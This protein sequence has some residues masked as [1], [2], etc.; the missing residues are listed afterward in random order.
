MLTMRPFLFPI[1]TG[2]TALAHWK[3][4][5]TFTAITLSH[6]SSSISRNGLWWRSANKPALLTRISTVPNS[7]TVSDTRFSTDFFEVTSARTKIARFWV[8]AMRSATGLPSSTSETTTLAPAAARH[9][10]NFILEPRIHVFLPRLSLSVGS[11]PGRPQ[12]FGLVCRTG[13]NGSRHQIGKLLGRKKSGRGFPRPDF[14]RYQTDT[15]PA[16]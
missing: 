6:S 10:R 4:P 16:T 9:D 11:Y 5:R 8:S 15:L 13:C 7:R 12:V 2:A 1:I 14:I 3:V